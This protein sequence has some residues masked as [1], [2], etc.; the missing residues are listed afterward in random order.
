MIICHS[1]RSEDELLSEAKNL[2]S[3]AQPKNVDVTEILPPFGR[4]N[5]NSEERS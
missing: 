5:D 4:L 3:I 1:K 2:G